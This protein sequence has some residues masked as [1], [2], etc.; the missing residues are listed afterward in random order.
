[1]IKEA[2][3]LGGGNSSVLTFL[4]D[5]PHPNAAKILINWFLS[6]EGQ[7]TWQRVMNTIVLEESDSMRI[8]ISK[9]NVIPIGRRSKGKIYPMLGF[10]DPRPVRKFYAE[11]ITKAGRRLR[12]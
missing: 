10:L 1:M 6:R 3:A 4:K 9:D 12:E 7:E 11:L 2:G 5:A 8:D